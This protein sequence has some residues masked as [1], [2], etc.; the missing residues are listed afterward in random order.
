MARRRT[1]EESV[2]SGWKESC[3]WTVPT[4]EERPRR[5]FRRGMGRERGVCGRLWRTVGRGAGLSW[6]AER[7]GREAVDIDDDDDEE[8]VVE[9]AG[10]PPLLSWAAWAADRRRRR[11]KV[12][13][14]QL[15]RL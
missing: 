8:V 10:W 5:L 4:N 6:R 11:L 15:I 9:H 3:E 14:T 7:M 1:R 2:G 12:D 13:D